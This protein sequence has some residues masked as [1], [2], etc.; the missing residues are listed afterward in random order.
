MKSESWLRVKIQ[1]TCLSI[2]VII[3]LLSSIAFAQQNNIRFGHIGTADGLSSSNVIS[4][5]QDRRGFMWFGTRDGL[6]KYDGYTYTVYKNDPKDSNSLSNNIINAMKEDKNGVLWIGTWG[7]GLNKFDPKTNIFTA[8]KHDLKNTNSLANDLINKI[9][10]DNKGILWICTEGGGADAFEIQKQTFTHHVHNPSDPNSISQDVIK[11]IIEDS[12]HQIWMAS[13][14]AGINILDPKTGIFSHLTHQDGIPTSLSSNGTKVL[15]EDRQHQVWVGTRG[16]G[17]N[18]FNPATHDFKIYKKIN[19]SFN[20]L[21]HDYILSISQDKNDN[22]WIGTENGGLS[23]FNQQQNQFMNYQQDD[24]DAGSLSNNSVWSIYPDSKG[25]MWVG[26]FAGDINFW[27]SDV[28]QF[29]LFRHSTNPQSLS[30]N[31]VLC[32]YEDTQGQ[33]WI[34]TDG[35]GLNRF[36]KNT[37]VFKHFIHEPNNPRTIC[38]NYV[39]NVLEDSRG[40]LWIGTWADGITVLDP[41]RNVYK[42]FRHDPNNPSSLPTDNIY[43]LYED[44]N[45]NI[46]VGAF[47]GGLNLFHPTD[48]SFVHYFHDETDLKTIASNTINSIFEDNLGTLW[49]GTDG[50]GMD[51]FN[52]KKQSFTHFRHLDGTNSL[53]NNIVSS[54]LQDKDSTLWIGTMSGLNH[55]DLRKKIFTIFRTSDGL[56][57]DA[58]AGIQED[59]KGYLWISTNKGLTRFNPTKKTF[60]NFGIADGLQSDEFKMQ[61]SCKSRSGT[62]YF[63]GNNG[64]NAFFPDSIELIKYDPP[65][66]MTDFLIQ[67]QRVN[68]AVGPNDPSPLKKPIID[69]KSISLPYQSSVITFEF[70]SLNYIIG[71]KKMYSYMLEGFDK[72]WNNV[73]T[74]RTATYTNLDP[75]NYTFKVRG[76]NNKVGWS[77]NI[78]EMKLIIVPPFW[79]TMWFKM[80]VALTIGGSAC[81]FYRIR[82]KAIQA[83]KIKLQQLVQRQTHELID[84]NAEESK[85]RI[86]AEK[87]RAEADKANMAKSIFLATMSHEIRTPMNGVI[88]MASLLEQTELTS[89]QRVYAQTISTCGESLLT[90]INDI[91]DFSKIESGKMELESKDFDLRT[92]IEE[93]LDVFAGKAATTGLDLVYQIDPN[94]PSHIMGDSLRL[95]QILI[96]L[97][98]NA[99]KFTN[100]GE[101]CIQVTLVKSYKTGKL[102]IGFDVRDTGIGIAPDKRERLFKAFTQVD[103]STTRK[104]GG[105][106]LGLVICAKLVALMGGVIQVESEVEVGTRFNFTIQVSAGAQPFEDLVSNGIAGMA[107]KHVLVV[108]DNATNRRIIKCQLEDWNMIP[109]MADG[110]KQA[111]ELL[112]GPDIFDLVLS[113]MQMPGMD[114]VELATII[115]KNHPTLPIIVLTSMGD[116]SFK[117]HP[118][119]FQSILTKPVRQHLLYEHIVN[120][121]QTPFK[122]MVA[123][124]TTQKILGIEFSQQYPLRILL[125]EDNPINQLLAITIF[126]KMGYEPA[127]ANSGLEVID[128]MQNM[129]FDVIFMDV[130]MP[131]MDGIEATKIIRRDHKSQPVIIAMTANAMQS[132]REQCLKAGMDDYL[133]KPIDLNELVAMLEKWGKQVLGAVA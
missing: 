125:A 22:L 15:F 26:T 20:C 92:C 10:F 75:G 83:Q 80:L 34:G 66:V 96:N 64:F 98:G 6:N 121:F 101:V 38:G 94:I 111:L 3:P 33:L 67:N 122:R 59:D 48:S 100:K 71:N 90:V 18:V 56:P 11:D 86:D 29:R 123:K 119:L 24:I 127:V 68:V 43:A 12:H 17:V 102:E 87:A 58:I 82:M 4:I 114:G 32:L 126:N 89:E 91:L 97:V 53:S 130:Q 105:T 106:G 81:W 23:V 65:L 1:K 103:S 109:S 54:I 36:D 116:D 2:L 46:W 78:L 113:D 41:Q 70:T 31:K 74:K 84:L 85:A 13:S 108:D 16:G 107:G 120:Q 72:T 14:D 93:V 28:N 124:E 51:M 129:E 30:H 35:G 76:F 95:R 77:A 131:E 62:M 42:H 88:G 50:Q 8:F 57:S 60:S 21:A 5:L 40:Y 52:S 25:D 63:G 73:G 44:K 132:D 61:A 99:I 115:K 55:F 47:N 27:S 19:G 117:Q 110:A 79:M 128:K 69:T 37:G 133:S 112:S 49:I 118:G 39:L 9:C 7:G 104:Y 45:K